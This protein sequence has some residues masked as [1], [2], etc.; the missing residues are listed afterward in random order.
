MSAGRSGS[1]LLGVILNNFPNSVYVGELYWW[2]KERG[3]PQNDRK[4]IHTFWDKINKNIDIDGSFENN[5][6][7]LF[8]YHSS[9]IKLPWIGRLLMKKEYKEMN[10]HLFNS[11]AE[12]SR[13]KYIIDSSHYPWRAYWLRKSGINIKLIYLYKDPSSV[14]SSFAKKNIEHEH[15]NA[16]SANIYLFVVSALSTLVYSSFN[17]NDRIKVIY[18]DLVEYPQQTINRLGNFLN[19]KDIKIDIDN[20]ST[21]PIFMGNRIRHNS[22]I[23]LNLNNSEN[24]NSLGKMIT[25][26]IQLPFL[27]LNSRKN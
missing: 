24:K 13:K 4:E 7:D 17:K 5:Y 1:T 27:I 11:I 18:E 3:I 26:I 25:N 21:G 16:L 15:K 19:T 20:L 14:V 2:N 6:Y 23:K 22:S 9:F 10:T 12:S 8:E